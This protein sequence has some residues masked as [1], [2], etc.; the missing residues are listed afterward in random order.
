MIVGFL[1]AL[2]DV[3]LNS[4]QD[5]ARWLRLLGEATRKAWDELNDLHSGKL[6][7]QWQVYRS[8]RPH[9]GGARAVW[10]SSARTRSRR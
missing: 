9:E 5:P 6:R 10:G 4:G 7:D 8:W 1:E 2:Q 3:S